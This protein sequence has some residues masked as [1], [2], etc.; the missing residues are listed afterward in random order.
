MRLFVGK[1]VGMVIRDKLALAGDDAKIDATVAVYLAA[2]IGW[3]APEVDQATFDASIVVVD[4]LPLRAS[5]IDIVANDPSPIS[6]V[7]RAILLVVLD[8]FNLLRERVND[9]AA[10][11]AAATSLADL[12]T[13][14]A[15]RSAMADRTPAQLKTAVANKLNSGSAD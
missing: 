15:A 13:R 7:N 5:A 8:E 1:D 3:T 6:K 11:V 12:K 14:W 2:R 10:D 9:I 4:P